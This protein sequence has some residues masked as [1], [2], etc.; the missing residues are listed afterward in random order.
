MR[1]GEYGGN[2]VEEEDDIIVEKGSE[3]AKRLDSKEANT[4]Y[5]IEESKKIFESSVRRANL[6]K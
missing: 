1:Y 2:F 5:S 6:K 3:L 4:F